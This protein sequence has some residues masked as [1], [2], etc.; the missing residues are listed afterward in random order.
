MKFKM[1]FILCF[2]MSAMTVLANEGHDHEN[3]DDD[4][5]RE[6]IVVA[7]DIAAKLGLTLRSAGSGK[8]DRQVTFPAEIVLNRDRVSQIKPAYPALV[9]ELLVEVG[10]KVQSGDRLAVLENRETLSMFV[11]IAPRS[12]IV[13][14]KNATVG[15]S[16]GED[17][18]LFEVA[19]LTSVWVEISIFPQYRHHVA[20]GRRVTLIAADGHEAETHV[21]YISPLLSRETRTVQ[22]RGILENPEEDFMPGAFVQARLTV[23]SVE[24][25][26]VVKR[27]AVQRI[28]GESVVFVREDGG[29]VIREV[30]T[31]LSD[32][33][34][35]QIIHGLEAGEWY[36][37]KGAFELKAHIVTSG[38]DPHAGHGH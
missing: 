10:D 19:D 14:I 22:A 13:T 15:E 4:H 7:P 28:D 24:A 27:E 1:I 8:V 38:L 16:L 21:H 37:V 36:V 33:R 2:L 30:Q 35:V 29:Y 31:G 25:D 5:Q 34:Y 11:L 6:A 18:L 3:C 17:E 9:R 26:V 23:E 32:A 12:G 20:R